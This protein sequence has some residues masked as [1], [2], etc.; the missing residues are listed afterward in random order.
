MNIA[1]QTAKHL[2]D[3]HFGGNWTT[4]N[5]RDTLADVTWQQAITKVDSFNTIAVLT[6]HVNYFV[7][8]LLN[9]LKGNPLNA[10]DKFSFDHPPINSQEDW[11]AMKN[12]IY[13]EAEAAARLIE[14]LPDSKLLETFEDEKYGSYYRNINGIIEHMHYHLGQM[15]I[16]KKLITKQ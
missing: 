3:V 9:V 6:F 10:N 1:Q 16:I 8:A 5:L 11:E 7:S 4:S 13:E 12:S 15:V 14:Q 2:R